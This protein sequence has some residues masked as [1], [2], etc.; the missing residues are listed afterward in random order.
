MDILQKDLTLGLVFFLSEIIIIWICYKFIY[1]K[2]NISDRSFL[3]FFKILIGYYIFMLKYKLCPSQ[4]NHNMDEFLQEYSKLRYSI[5]MYSFFGMAELFILP[6]I[7]IVIRRYMH[8]SFLSFLIFYLAGLSVLLEQLYESRINLMFL[9]NE[10]QIFLYKF[11]KKKKFNMKKNITNKE[12]KND[13][14]QQKKKVSILEIILVWLIIICCVAMFVLELKNISEKNILELL[15][16]KDFVFISPIYIA[17]GIA[18]LVFY[19]VLQLL[20]E[21]SRSKIKQKVN[22]RKHIENKEEIE[23]NLIGDYIEELSPWMD[24]ILKMC[25]ILNI[26]EV[27]VGIGDLDSKKVVSVISDMQMPIIIITKE[28]FDKSKIFFPQEHFEIIK[29]LIAHELVHI[30]YMDIKWMKKVSII[31]LSYIFIA[32]FI[33]FYAYKTNSIFL[34]GIVIFMFIVFVIFRAFYD[35]RYWNQVMEFRADRIGMAISNTLPEI[36]E[37]ALKCAMEEVNDEKQN[38]TGIL[39]KIYRKKAEKQIHPGIERRIYE[40]KRGIHW[41]IKEYFRYLWLVNWNIITGKGWNI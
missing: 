30:Y 26:K 23:V 1:K 33:I 36:L 14:V 13:K 5:F 34:L 4:R 37:K 6:V 11:N 18:F 27:A 19:I 7:V 25:C 8:L 3:T 10:S 28:V 39:Y 16:L 32:L 9:L 17:L 20:D 40:A 35:E 15:N 2:K 22:Y 38:E 24:D 12:N 21:E 41:R 29:L 31:A